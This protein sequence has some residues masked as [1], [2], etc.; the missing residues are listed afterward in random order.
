MVKR[1]AHVEEKF[2]SVAMLVDYW[3]GDCFLASSLGQNY[4]CHSA[5]VRKIQGT[6]GLCNKLLFGLFELLCCP[7]DLA[8]E[9]GNLEEWA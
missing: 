8:R 9:G 1:D 3:F 4:S 6:M 2:Y 5:Q 7:P